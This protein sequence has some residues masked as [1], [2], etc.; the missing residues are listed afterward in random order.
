VYIFFYFYVFLLIV[1]IFG[2][3]L[4]LPFFCRFLQ[5][6][7]FFYSVVTILFFCMF[8]CIDMFIKLMF[9][10]AFFMISTFFSE[11]RKTWFFGYFWPFFGPP[12]LAIF[13]P[14]W[15]P[16][17]WSFLTLFSVSSH[18]SFCL[19]LTSFTSLVLLEREFFVSWP[20]TPFYPIF[21]R[22]LIG[23]I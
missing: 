18:V 22:I 9:F 3:F 1:A 23:W 12:F 4:H 10:I 17:F 15:T 20:K 14:F 5:V 21:L 13:D 19:S 11:S 8:C 7:R 6:L 2:L 16:V